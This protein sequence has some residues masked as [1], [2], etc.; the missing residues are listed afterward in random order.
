MHDARHSGTASVLGPRS[1]T[2][3]WQRKL[4]AN[5]TAGPVIG[6]DESVIT[7]SNDGVLNALDP[8]TGD[9]RWQFDAQGSFGN[10]LSTSAAILADGTI[11]WPGPQG[12]LFGLSATGTLLWNV[13]LGGFV[14]SPAVASSGR[15]YV[16]TMNGVLSAIDIGTASK[17]T[18]AW[19]LDVG[20]TA[21]GS[22]SIGPDGT[23]FTT[24]TNALVGVVDEGTQARERWRFGIDE[25]IEVSPAVGPDG[26]VVIGSND[27]FQYGLDGTTGA[28]RWKVNRGDETYSSPIVTPDGLAYYGDHTATLYVVDVAKGTLIRS[29]TTVAKVG[30]RSWGIWTAPAIDAEGAAFYGTRSGHIFGVGPTGKVLFD[31]EVGGT[32]DSY[33]ALGVDGTLFIGSSNG[34]FTAIA[35]G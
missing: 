11:A 35:P 34:Q 29:T 19:K 2:I 31:V 7:A 9:T 6:V 12:T 4:G 14:L 17:P 1:G 20:G 3:R 33:P 23:I 10:D 8:A 16:G 32:V 5:A 15:L 30:G 28:L 18:V 21:Y 22:P 25:L 13:E 26:T 24:S 27:R